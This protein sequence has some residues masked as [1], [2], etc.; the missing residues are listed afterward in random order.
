MTKEQAEEPSPARLMVNEEGEPVDAIEIGS[1]YLHRSKHCSPDNEDVDEFF[2]P[3]H[4]MNEL[5]CQLD[6]YRELFASGQ[7]DKLVPPTTQNWLYH[8]ER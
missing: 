6:E 8:F 7:A 2:K 3:D 5:T 4:A 1:V